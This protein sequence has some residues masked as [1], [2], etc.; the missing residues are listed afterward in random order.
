MTTR[1]LRRTR[2]CSQVVCDLDEMGVSQ[3]DLLLLHGPCRRR[4]DSVRMWKG[5]ERALDEGLVRAIGVSNF[6]VADLAYLLPRAR[7]KPAVNQCEMSLQRH[8]NT[9][10]SYIQDHGITYSAWGVL[11][12]CPWESSIAQRLASERNA[13]VAQICM[14]W[15]S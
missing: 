6:E 3:V 8:N 4:I 11:S 5:L 9:D 2:A 10:I 13:T 14:R 1:T 15:C 7:V 12:G